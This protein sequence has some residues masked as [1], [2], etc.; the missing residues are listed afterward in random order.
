M[1]LFELKDL[2][3]Q[4]SVRFP[5]DALREGFAVRAADG[6]VHAYVN[7]CP[8]R[9]QPVDLGDG[10]L[11]NLRGQLECSAHWARFDPASGACLG[12]P[13]D[14]NGLTRLAIEVRD[15][16]AWLTEAASALPE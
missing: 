7:V 10:R 5:L 1:K 11:F 8:H 9:L 12:G 13:C 3:P 15:G 6:S 14:G 2:L 16:A 4:G